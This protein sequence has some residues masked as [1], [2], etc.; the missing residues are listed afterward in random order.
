MIGNG[1][2][3]VKEPV[4]M[5]KMEMRRPSTAQRIRKIYKEQETPVRGPVLACLP[6]RAFTSSPSHSPTQPRP[7]P[8]PNQRWALCPLLTPI[9]SVWL[10]IKNR[11]PVSFRLGMT[12]AVSVAAVRFRTASEPELNPNQTPG[13]NQFEPENFQ[14]YL[15]RIQRVLGVNQCSLK[16]Y[17]V[18]KF[19]HKTEPNRTPA[20]LSAVRMHGQER[21]QQYRD[22][23]GMFGGI[24]TEHVV[25]G[26]GGQLHGH[27]EGQGSGD[28]GAWEGEGG[29]QGG[30]PKVRRNV[31]RIARMSKLIVLEVFATDP[32]KMGRE[33]ASETAL[34]AEIS[35]RRADN[36]FR[37]WHRRHGKAEVA[38]SED[39]SMFITQSFGMAGGERRDIE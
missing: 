34:Y 30:Q 35:K 32:N 8:H 6:A 5:W 11:I 27:G 1:E 21:G 31:H 26:H 20:T 24:G 39:L 36:S 29:D 37:P 17:R 10:L 16:K 2:P 4:K 18:R 28:G 7:Q 15:E 23:G 25:R 3:K 38:Y 14:G 19:S 9:P 13:A 12:S 33:E 22:G